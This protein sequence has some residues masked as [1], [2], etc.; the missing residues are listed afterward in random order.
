MTEKE[1]LYVEDALEHIKM[2]HKKCMRYENMVKDQNLKK[3]ICDIKA[4]QETLYER[5]YDLL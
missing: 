1:L 2:M 4:K 3:V 5:L